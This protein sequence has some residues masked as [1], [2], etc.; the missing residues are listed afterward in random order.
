[1]KVD[2]IGMNPIQCP[3]KPLGS[4]NGEKAVVP[5]QIPEKNMDVVVYA[6]AN[7]AVPREAL[8]HALSRCAERK[9]FMTGFSRQRGNRKHD[10][11][12]AANINR[13]DS[14]DFQKLLSLLSI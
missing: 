8:A 14:D 4:Q 7:K 10:V 1:M 5:C 9:Y 3:A 12:C 11:S 2:D 6:T 13:I